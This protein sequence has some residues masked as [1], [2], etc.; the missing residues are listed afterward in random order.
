MA[1]GGSALDGVASLNPNIIIN[2]RVGKTR[3]GM[4]GMSDDQSSPGDFGTPEQQIPSTGLP[5]GVDWESCMTMNNTWGFKKNDNRWKSTQALVRNLVDVVSKGGNYLLNVGPTPEGEI[6]AESVKRL[7]QIGDWMKSNGVSIHGATASP[8]KKLS[9]GKATTGKDGTLYLHVFVWPNGKELDV[10]L[11]NASASIKPLYASDTQPAAAHKGDTLAITGLPAA[12]PDPY[13]PVLALKL[14]GAPQPTIATIKQQP[15][16]TLTLLAT[17]CDVHATNAK[18]EKKGDHPYNIGYW[19]NI[20][21]T[22]SWDTTIDKP[23]RFAI[24]IEYSLGGPPP[25]SEINLEFGKVKT[26]PV[27]LAAR[28]DFLDFTTIPAGTVELPAG[29]ITI[30]L[31]P[32]KK[33]GIAVMDLRQIQLKPTAQK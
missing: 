24:T 20:K 26:L 18:L 12:A 5:A 13:D 25:G 22:V 28:K 31:H 32:T 19:T 7:A 4:T 11:A 33:S 15:D 9:W 6:P 30:T 14:D 29:P 3:K 16:G 21:D 23:G 2:N 8:F 17:E 1:N 10:P 27:K